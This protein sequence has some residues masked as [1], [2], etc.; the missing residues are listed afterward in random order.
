METGAPK[1]GKTH[2]GAFDDSCWARG[3][4][5]G[6]YGFP[7]SSRHTGDMAFLNEGRRLARYFMDNLP[8]DGICY[9]D[10]YYKDGAYEP[11]DSSAMVIAACGVLEQLKLL[12]PT[13]E[14]A[15]RCR[16]FVAATFRNLTRHYLAPPDQNGVLLHATYAKN[17]SNLGV[18]E[19]NIWGDYFYM[20][21]CMRLLDAWTPYW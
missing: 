9:W 2:Q 6:V 19:F 16:D 15:A 4:A 13:S 21:L 20:E 18:D 11:R 8:A 5:W 17:P 7:L 3:Q 14:E 10:M 1:Y 12:P